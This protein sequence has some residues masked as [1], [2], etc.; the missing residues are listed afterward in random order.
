M[1]WLTGLRVSAGAILIQPNQQMIIFLDGRYIE[2]GKQQCPELT[3]LP[4]ASLKE[5]LA[6]R[7]IKQ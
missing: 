5:E 6:N 4:Y 7:S 2:A 3:I 1:L